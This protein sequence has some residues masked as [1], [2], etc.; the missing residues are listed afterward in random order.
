[1]WVISTDFDGNNNGKIFRLEVTANNGQ[2][3]LTD[4]GVKLPEFHS[5]DR[6]VAQI[7]SNQVLVQLDSGRTVI[8]NLPTTGITSDKPTLE[9]AGR[10]SQ[11]RPWSEMVVLPNGQVMASGGSRDANQLNDVAYHAEMWDRSTKQWTRAASQL[12]PRLYHATGVLLADGRVLAVGGGAPSPTL[13]LNAQIFSP[14]YLFAASGAAQAR[15][16]IT[17]SS[18]AFAFGATATLSVSGSPTRATLVR[19]GATTH[20]YNS[21]QSYA[22][23]T[24]LSNNGSTMTVRLPSNNVVAP[25][26][27]FLS[28]VNSAGVPSVSRIIKL[29]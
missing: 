19:L 5:W 4:T 27:Y 6:P 22:P 20:A 15:P 13:E 29:G 24:V 21:E 10:L 11:T 18:T 1:V 14:P 2:G 17:A 7:S 3:L 23:L 16:S 28:V 26:Y 8:V 25:G 12:R 9:D